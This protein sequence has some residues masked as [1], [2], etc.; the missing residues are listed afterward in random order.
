M[1]LTR[2]ELD[3]D[4]RN[5][6]KLLSSRSKIHG[7]VE[8]AFPTERKRHLWR[9]DMLN[10]KLYLLILSEEKPKLDTAVQEYGNVEEGYA[11]KEYRT[12][13]SRVT[14]QSKWRFR[15]VAN[16]TRSISRAKEGKRGKVKACVTVLLQEKWLIE[17]AEKYGFSLL[18]D[19]VHVVGNIWHHF[20]KQDEKENHVAIREV[21]Y[22][23]ILT[24]VNP[25]K[26]KILL[27]KGIGR[28]KA[29]GMGMLTI[30]SL[31]GGKG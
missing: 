23:G 21:S 25:E 16:P 27:C 19:E 26:F 5:T 12:L 2:M 18:E 20:Y 17:R 30:V 8:S 4:K 10:G 3:T 13:L 7:M 22:E 24:V 15:L 1:Y 14:E 28:G 11:S 31:I 6:R 9:L 29:Y